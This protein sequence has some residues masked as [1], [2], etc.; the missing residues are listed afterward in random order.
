MKFFKITVVSSAIF[1]T[2]CQLTPKKDAE[3]VYDLS[4]EINERVSISSDVPSDEFVRL[5]SATISETQHPFEPY[6][7]T[8]G[9][10]LQRN[11]SGYWFKE[12]NKGN[13]FNKAHYRIPISFDYS[14]D[15]KYH[16]FEMKSKEGGKIYGYG[17][18]FT[19]NDSSI[20]SFQFALLEKQVAKSVKK[21]SDIKYTEHKKL[22][23]PYKYTKT[24]KNDDV[25]AFA[26]IQRLFPQSF[27]STNSKSESEKSGEFVI[28]NVKINFKLF[29]YKKTSKVEI[30]YIQNYE[31]EITYFAFDSENPKSE[32]KPIVKSTYR[33]NFNRSLDKKILSALN[34]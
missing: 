26:N 12:V 11:Y 27:L 21:L 28:D 17:F 7:I 15:S 20:N 23:K 19:S 30:E 32:R 22:F 18:G 24:L 33:S 31:K 8:F 3:E 14:T 34:D 29:P 16:K 2:A 1:L 25:T 5:I 6:E 13:E 9:T 4:N 10:G